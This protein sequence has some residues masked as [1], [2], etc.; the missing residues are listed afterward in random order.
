VDL[1]NWVS[2]WEL[3]VAAVAQKCADLL[4]DLG[5]TEEA[6]EVALHA[7]SIIP[8]HTALT[9]TLMRA[10][11]ANGDR[12]AV[13]SVYQEHLGALEALDLDEAEESTTDLCERLLGA[14]TG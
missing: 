6:V 12:L 2:I 9:E 11:A 10:H 3:K 14:K 5:R 7:L 13:K 4:L 1:E 8:T